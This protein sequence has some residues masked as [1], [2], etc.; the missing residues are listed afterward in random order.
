MSFVV[1]IDTEHVVTDF[2][3]V[4]RRGAGRVLRDRDGK[5]LWSRDT[6][7]WIG[8]ETEDGL[9]VVSHILDVEND[10]VGAPL[11]IFGIRVLSISKH[12]RGADFL[13]NRSYDG[14]RIIR[15]LLRLHLLSKN[16]TS[17]YVLRADKDSPFGGEPIIC[18]VKEIV[19]K[20]GGDSPIIA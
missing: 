14:N 15:T 12:E 2:E 19:G 9:K 20:L 1:C 7:W 5:E 13:T 18:F 10:K 4:S 16:T 6:L 3:I 17:A 8:Y 11:I